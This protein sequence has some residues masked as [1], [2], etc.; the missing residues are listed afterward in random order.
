M[1]RTR[2]GAAGI[3]FSAVGLGCAAMG[4]DPQAWGPVDD[5]ESIAAIHAALDSGINWIDASPNYGGGHAETVVGRALQD[6]RDQAHVVTKC[7]LPRAAAPGQRHLGPASILAECDASLRRL[8]TDRIDLYLCQAPDPTTPLADTLGAMEQLMQQGKVRAIG[9][10]GFG[11]DLLNAWRGHGPLHAIMSPLSLL[12]RDAL[13]DLAPYA[14]RNGAAFLACSPLCRGLLSG[15]HSPLSR[16]SD[17]RVRDPQFAPPRLGHNCRI[18]E[19]LRTL[20]SRRE[21]P[22]VQLALAWVLA[23]PGV[24]CAVVGARRPSQVRQAAAALEWR[25]L[26]EEMQ[27]IASILAA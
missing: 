6:R 26:P 10:M 18:V 9:A 5:N 22:L 1:K 25:L 23:Q 7:G 14:V 20:A 2:I 21:R 15:Q 8:R 11:C 27:Q 3:E 12:E 19:S 13:G 17:L 4:Q 24:A 16:F